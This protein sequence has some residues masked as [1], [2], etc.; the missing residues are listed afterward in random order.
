MYASALRT[1]HSPSD[2][3]F[4]ETIFQHRRLFKKAAQRIRAETHRVTVNIDKTRFGTAILDRIN[5]RD[6]CERLCND[7]VS[8]SALR[9]TP[10]LRVK[11]QFR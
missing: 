1:N 2:S 10:R 11:P 7:F 4:A 9:P 3:I 6:K 8:R 5:C